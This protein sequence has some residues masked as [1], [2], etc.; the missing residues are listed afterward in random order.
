MVDLSP[1]APTEQIQAPASSCYT[2]AASRGPCCIPIVGTYIQ[3]LERNSR[4]AKSDQSEPYDRGGRSVILQ[5]RGPP[6]RTVRTCQATYAGRRWGVGHLHLHLTSRLL[7]SVHTFTPQQR[8]HTPAR[9]Q[10][11]RTCVPSLI[12]ERPGYWTSL[13]LLRRLP[14]FLLRF[15]ISNKRRPSVVERCPHSLETM[16]LLQKYAYDGCAHGC[17]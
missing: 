9:A 1:L 5:Q 14:G 11:D 7:F 15:F 3:G 16:P 12:S 4:A 13:L 8:Q 10:A 6:A 2:A 17:P